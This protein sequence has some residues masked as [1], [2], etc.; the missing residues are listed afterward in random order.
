MFVVKNSKT[1]KIVK[2]LKTNRLNRVK[3][4][5]EGPIVEHVVADEWLKQGKLNKNALWEI[6]GFDNETKKR[7]DEECEKTL[8]NLV[9]EEVA[10]R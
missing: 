6:S 1:G 4:M 8:P 9:I 3:A 2:E 5:V 10:E 7:F